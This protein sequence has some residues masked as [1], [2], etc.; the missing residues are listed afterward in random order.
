MEVGG[1]AVADVDAG[2]GDPVQF[3]TELDLGLGVALAADRRLDE[4]P[5]GKAGTHGRML[6][7][8]QAG[9]GPAER[10]ADVDAVAA[11]RPAAEERIAGLADGGDGDDEL[12]R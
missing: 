5:Q 12:F 8:M 6:Q 4:L 10:P 3:Q 9:S 7:E 11:L 1:E 2:R